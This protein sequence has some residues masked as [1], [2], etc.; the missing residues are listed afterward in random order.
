MKK[1]WVYVLKGGEPFSISIPNNP[2]FEH[3]GSMSV[4][5]MY[6]SP[7]EKKGVES[8]FMQ[9][10]QNFLVYDN[11]TTEKENQLRNIE[12][13]V[14]QVFKCE[15]CPTCW[16]FD[17]AFSNRCGVEDLQE[18]LVKSL[19]KDPNSQSH[20]DYHKCPIYSTPSR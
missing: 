11:S 4:W 6:L 13:D 8:F 14:E 3:N 12:R 2:S 7:F 9:R 17:H 18:D 10:G 1:Y 16:W 19:L 20:K 15:K 5:S